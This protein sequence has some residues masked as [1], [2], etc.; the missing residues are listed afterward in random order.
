MKNL[1]IILAVAALFI[2]CA[3]Q[4]TVYVPVE[5]QHKIEYRDSIIHITDTI[6]VE[7]PKEKIV[8]VVPQLDTSRLETKLAISTA[9]LDTTKR[10]INHTLE[11]KPTALKQAI[12]TVI[13]VQTKTEYLEKPTIVEVETPVKYVPTIYKY[14]LWFSIAI[15]AF[16]LRGIFLKI[17]G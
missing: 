16:V 1:A 7:I 13:V 11:H 15:I 10:T 14:S 5:G 2:G 12:D 6:K 8:E 9:F 4:K 17:R 3:A